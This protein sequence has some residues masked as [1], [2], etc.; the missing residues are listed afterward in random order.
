MF[1]AN[2]MHP[3][4]KTHGKTL[5]NAIQVPSSSLYYYFHDFY[6]WITYEQVKH[7]S[8]PAYVIFADQSS[9]SI[10]LIKH[11]QLISLKT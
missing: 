2:G 5:F 3:Q 9:I 1:V 6:I 11:C 8:T 4:N 10:I 7:L